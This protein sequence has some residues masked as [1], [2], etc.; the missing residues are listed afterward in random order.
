M[1]AFASGLPVV[2]S[3]IPTIRE[4]AGRAAVL[5]DPRDTESL[6]DGIRYAIDHA[7]DLMRK[8]IER[9]ALFSF[10]RFRSNILSLY[11]KIEEN[12]M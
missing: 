10:D 4:V 7:D 5:C 3:D 12:V 1:E 6:K 2:T 11:R 8:G 9:S